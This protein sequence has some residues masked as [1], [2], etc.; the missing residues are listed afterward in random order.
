MVYRVDQHGLVRAHVGLNCGFMSKLSV[1]FDLGY[2]MSE[3]KGAIL[4]NAVIAVAVVSI[5]LGVA[6]YTAGPI[7][8]HISS[9]SFS[10]KNSVKTNSQLNLRFELSINSTS[11]HN[12]ESINVTAAVFNSLNDSNHVSNMS[13]W[14][15]PN[16]LR[17]GQVCYSPVY[18]VFLQ[19]YVSDS[20]VSNATP[21]YNVPPPPWVSSC[22]MKDW[23]SFSFLPSS[24]IANTTSASGQ[25]SGAFPIM[26]E[27]NYLG[28]YTTKLT[29][30]G[31]NQTMLPQFLLFQRG[32]YTV[33]AGDEW[34]DFSLLYFTVS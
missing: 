10:T 19:G 7:A 17:Y 34:G 26:A 1:Q 6:F 25:A 23:T 18:I 31:Q 33:L 27:S 14:A 20:N 16:L 9:P 11:L 3:Y 21:L 8:T 12:G 2:P 15:F 4:R 28:Y 24:D 5:L 13:N 30:Q 22:I 29:P 32:T